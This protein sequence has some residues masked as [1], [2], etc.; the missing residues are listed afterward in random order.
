M[1]AFSTINFPFQLHFSYGLQMSTD[2]VFVFI[3]FCLVSDFPEEF[4]FDPW[5]ILE[6]IF[7]MIIFVY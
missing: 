2:C 4:L 1:F 3:N 6:V 7:Q 5:I